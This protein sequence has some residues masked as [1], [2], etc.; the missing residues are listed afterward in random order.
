MGKKLCVIPMKNQ[1]EQACN[2]ALL[3][4]MGVTVISEFNIDNK[5]L[6]FWIENKTTTQ[7]KYPDHTK[8]ILVKI[9]SRVEL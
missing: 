5:Q 2:A 6:K 9:L 1:Y 3:A 8:E 7:I 4:E